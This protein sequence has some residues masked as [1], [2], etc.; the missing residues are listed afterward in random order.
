LDAAALKLESNNFSSLEER[1]SLFET[2]LPLSMEES[3]QV[4]VVDEASFSPRVKDLSVASDLAGGAQGS[5]IWGQTLRFADKEGGSVR[6]AQPGILVEPWNPIAG[7]NWIYDSM[8]Q[9][10][11]SDNGVISDPYTGLSWPQRLERAEVTVREGLPVSK[12]LDWVDLKFESQIQVPADTWIDWDAS[13]QK[14]ITVGEKFPEGLTT[15]SR[16]VV[17]YPEDLYE[18]VSWHDG[19][20]ISAADFVM[21]II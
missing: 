10:G 9:R 17:Y 16:T 21:N 12:T 11:L 6:I 19:S 3:Y 13:N 20:P 8:P 15:N 14:F 2:V 5:L 18:T 4:W 1:R 7:T